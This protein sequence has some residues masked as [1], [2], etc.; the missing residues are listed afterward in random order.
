MQ[1]LKSVDTMHPSLKS[2]SPDAYKFEKTMTNHR[3]AYQKGSLADRLEAVRR[4]GFAITLK[5]SLPR[6]RVRGAGR[7]VQ[8]A[9]PDI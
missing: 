3:L 8:G 6:E 1:A 5:D 7:A 2:E 9:A 4:G